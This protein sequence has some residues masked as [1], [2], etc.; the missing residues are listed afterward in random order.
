VDLLGAGMRFFGDR[1]YLYS[2]PEGWVTLLSMLPA[3]RIAHPTVMLKRESLLKMSEWYRKEYIYAEDYDLWMRMLDAGLVL[4]N[5]PDV[6]LNYRVTGGAV[7]QARRKE[8]DEA[9]ER[10]KRRYRSDLTVVIPFSNENVEVENT[11]ISI[12]E[13]APGV[14]DI[15]LIDDGSDDGFDYGQVAGRYGCVYL[16]HPKR[17]GVAASRDDGVLLC[18]T[19]HF[20]LLD[21][22]MRFYDQDWDVMLSR[23]LDEHPRSLLCSRT[24]VLGKDSE[25][26][27]VKEHSRRSTFGA[28]IKGDLSPAWNYHDPNPENPVLSEI[29]CVLGAAYACSKEYWQEIGGL[30]GLHSYGYDETLL[31]MKAWLSGGKCLLIKNWDVGHIY[32][33]KYPYSLT[34]G[35]YSQNRELIEFLFFDKHAEKQPEEVK[36]HKRALMAVFR[37]EEE[38]WEIFQRMNGQVMEANGGV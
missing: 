28:Y 38:R 16:R 12:R 6:V 26:G 27:E 25:T 11:I 36:E 2:P 15:I 35:A 37:G 19:R 33:K 21:A 1:D 9:A 34:P 29:P 18:R 4:Y 24:V 17:M 13:T 8:V 22:H 23:L 7:T 20:L 32:R 30:F 5:I 31:S 14:R 10:V 3:N